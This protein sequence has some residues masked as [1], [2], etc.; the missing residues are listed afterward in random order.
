MKK[1]LAFALTIAMLGAGIWFSYRQRST[2]PDEP[3]SVIWLLLEKSKAGD[4]EG[5]LDCFTGQTRA[6]LETTAQGMG[7]PQFSDYLKQS[8]A[9]VKGVAV[10]DVQRPSEGLTTLVVEYVY[11][12]QNER[13]RMSL[14][15]GKDRWRIETAEAS[16]RI[17]PVIPYGKPVSEAQ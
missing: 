6:Q 12:D 13:Q 5:Y 14:K 9:P 8:V 3:E 15:K 2:V 16:Q 10:Y 4:V 7:L 17:Q 11:Q 1:T